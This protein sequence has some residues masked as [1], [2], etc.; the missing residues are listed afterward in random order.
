MSTASHKPLRWP[1]RWQTHWGPTTIIL[2]GHDTPPLT[3][4]VGSGGAHCGYIE[5]N[6]HHGP[7]LKIV[8]VV[9]R[10]TAVTII[11]V[12]K[13]LRLPLWQ[14][15]PWWHTTIISVLTLHGLRP[16]CRNE[17]RH[18]YRCGL[19]SLVAY[20]AT[21][22]I[23]SSWLTYSVVLMQLHGWFWSWHASCVTKFT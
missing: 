5:C 2:G 14:P 19:P 22:I 11:A 16:L 7:L 4:N 17:H 3:T 12:G 9:M 13:V 21:S 10:T 18:S 8:P 20:S 15:T 1:K 23:S 6:Y